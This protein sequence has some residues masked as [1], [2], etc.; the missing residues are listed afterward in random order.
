MKTSGA[1]SPGIIPTHSF[2]A[3][4]EIRRNGHAGMEI[5]G[6]GTRRNGIGKIFA[7]LLADT[8]EWTRRNGNGPRV[9]RRNS[10]HSC[11]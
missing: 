8:Q 7:A 3:R 10:C 11:V 9:T 4:S 1:F 5:D 6:A 2:L